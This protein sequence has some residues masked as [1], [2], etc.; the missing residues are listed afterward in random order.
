MSDLDIYAKQGFGN[1]SGIGDRPALLIIDFVVGHQTLTAG[2]YSIEESQT[3]GVV[4]FYGVD[5]K[6]TAIVITDRNA[7]IEYVNPRFAEL[8]G[9]STEEVV[10][11]SPGIISS[12]HTPREVYRELWETILAGD[13]WLGE[14][15]NRK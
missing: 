12:G 14:L 4:T 9:Y 15:H 6:Q 11:Q 7:T 1:R 13:K 3:N 2:P 8:T 10:G 5:S